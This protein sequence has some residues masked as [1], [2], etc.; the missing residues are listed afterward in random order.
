[1][2]ARPLC[3]R[4]PSSAEPELSRQFAPVGHKPDHAPSHSGLDHDRDGAPRGRVRC[5]PRCRRRRA[6]LGEITGFLGFYWET[7]QVLR[8]GRPK[9]RQLDGGG[10][11]DVNHPATTRPFLYPP[12]ASS[13]RSCPASPRRVPGAGAMPTTVTPHTSGPPRRWPAVLDAEFT[14]LKHR[15]AARQPPRSLGYMGTVVRWPLR[16]RATPGN[17]RRRERIY[18]KVRF[19]GMFIRTWTTSRPWIPRV[20]AIWAG[21][22]APCR[23][24]NASARGHDDA[25]VHDR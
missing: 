16:Y 2:R 19:Y 25:L 3:G 14:D 4:R 12:T 15:H 18:L 1:M 6:R 20:A 22:A 11:R 8:V 24:Y 17:Q 9:V 13:P 23:A 7:R 5:A 10:G 21:A